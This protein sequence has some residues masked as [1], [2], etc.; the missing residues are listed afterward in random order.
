MHCIKTKTFSKEKFVYIPVNSDQW[1]YEMKYYLTHGSAPHY[2]EPK[3]KRSLR[4]KSTQYHLIQGIL[5]RNNYDGVFLRCLEKKMQKRFYLNFMMA[6]L[7]GILEVTLLLTRSSEMVITGLLCSRTLMHMQGNVRNVK[8]Q[9]ER[10]KKVA[11][12]LQ[13]VII[14]H[15]FQQ[16]GLDVIGEINPNSSQLHKYILTTTDYFT[17]WTKQSP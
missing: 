10:E 6:Q 1:Y 13:P 7:V 4:L 2:L 17:R 8:G 5:C 12:P 15:P 16:W 14:E 9:L 3:K 11:F